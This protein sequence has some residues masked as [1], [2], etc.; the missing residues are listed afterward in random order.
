M[1]KLYTKT[2]VSELLKISKV[3]IDRECRRG[4][5]EFVKLGN[6]VRFTREMIEKYIQKNSNGAENDL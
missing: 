2:D 4:N 6:S 1:D 5:L 3:T